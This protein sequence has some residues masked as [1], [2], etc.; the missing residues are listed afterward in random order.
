MGRSKSGFIGI[1]GRPN[2]GKSSLLNA[3]MGEKIAITTHKPQ[4]TRNRI[5]GIKNTA[6]GQFIFLDTPGIH[7]ARNPMNRAMV[8]AAVDTLSD[9]DIILFLVECG[10]PLNDDDRLTIGSFKELTIPVMLIINKIDLV[11]KEE[12]LGLIDRLRHLHDFE[13]VIPL[14]ALKGFN[15]DTLLNVIGRH[16]PEG[17]PFFPPD[18]ITDATERFLAAE[19]IREKITLL[20]HQEVPYA[21]VVIVDSFKDDEKKNLIGIQATIHVEKHSQK[22]IIIGRGGTMLKRIGTQARIDMERFFN[23]RVFLELFVRV[24]KDWTRDSRFLDEMGYRQ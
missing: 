11:T 13:E 19:M 12:L 20:T 16:L 8:M 14:S 6:G 22:G 1:V 21:T 15:V 9:V 24:S 2:V 7:R 18:M 4:T 17:P 5:K 10:S 23:S 3:I